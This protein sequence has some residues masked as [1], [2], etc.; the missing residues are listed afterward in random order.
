ERAPHPRLDRA[1]GR[2]EQ[3]GYLAV[4][5]AGVERERYDVS[6]LLGQRREQSL[7]LVAR[8]RRKCGALSVVGRRDAL[9]RLLVAHGAVAQA[10][11]A[12][13][14]IDRTMVDD[15]QQPAARAA[16]ARVV[17]LRRAPGVDERLLADVVRGRG[18][19]ADPVREGECGVRMPFV[20]DL[21]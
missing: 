7:G 18:A 8:S 20:E 19:A 21:E 3:L 1:E 2:A 9:G 11:R 6:L 14:L 5:V 4:R 17:A 10:R 13:Y 12:P 15:R 16:E